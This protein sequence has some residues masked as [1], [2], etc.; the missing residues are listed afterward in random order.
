MKIKSLFLAA[1]VV[2]SSAVAFAGKDEP[3]KTG[4][5]VVRVKGSE[6]FK[7]I[8]KGVNVGKVKLSIY[9]GKGLQLLT[10]IM[11]GVDG[12]I[13]P[14]NFAGLDSGDY[15]IEIVDATG[16]RIEKVVYQ[17]AKS[18]NHIHISKLPNEDSKFLVAIASTG[19][20]LISLKI[21]DTNSNLLHSE[22]TTIAGDFARVYKLNT[23]SSGYTFEVT[24]KAGNT[25]TIKF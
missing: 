11:N 22:S 8:Y 3:T 21:F 25:K 13:V 16:K 7:V 6:I 20:D 9:N 24:D 1:L 14:V 15:S 19:S 12:F 5:A 10:Q 17:P 4:F 2:F 23:T 18:I